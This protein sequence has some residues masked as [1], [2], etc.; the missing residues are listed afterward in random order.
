GPRRPALEL[1]VDHLVAGRLERPAA[2]PDPRV[3]LVRQRAADEELALAGGGDGAAAVVGPG[4]GADDRRVA[5]AAR[6]LGGVAAGRG[7]G[8]EVTRRV[9]SDRPDRAVLVGL[10]GHRRGAG[11]AP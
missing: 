2:E 1:A 5:D 10:G 3:D 11:R 6:G 8:G 9:E 7:R 4:P